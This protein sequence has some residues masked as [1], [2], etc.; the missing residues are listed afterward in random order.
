MAEKLKIMLLY[1]ITENIGRGI[2][3]T[4]KICANQV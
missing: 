4:S 1:E 3:K 2:F